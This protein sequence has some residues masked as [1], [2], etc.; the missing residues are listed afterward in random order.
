MTNRWLWGIG[1]LMLVAAALPRPAFAQGDG[2]RTHWKE[3]LTGTNLVNLTYLHGSGNVNPLDP[4]KTVQPSA[5]FDVDIALIGYSRSFSL[6]GRT[7]IGS[8][9]VPV[10]GLGAEVAGAVVSVKDSANGFGDPLLQLDL[11]LFGTPAMRNIPEL[12]RYE[13]DF[14]VDLVFDLAIPIGE[15]DDD[16][17]ANIG[18]NR[19]YG[20]VGAPVMISLRDWVPGR[21]TTLELLPAVWFF[22][23]NDDLMDSTLKNNPL[24][25]LEAHLTHDFTEGFWGSFDAVWYTGAKSTIGGLT[26]DKLNDL[27]LGFTLGYNVTDNLMLIAG[28]TATLENKPGDLDLGVFRINLVYGW[29]RLLEGIGRLRGGS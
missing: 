1:V 6:F 11:N 14:T 22:E 10:G 18:Q 3:M 28:Y 13:P 26:G 19:W 15:Y 17:A 4:T 25:Q 27:G 2:P 12:L 29:H 20:R 7:A 5:D 23:D 9:L 8:L 16:S 24:F 21:R